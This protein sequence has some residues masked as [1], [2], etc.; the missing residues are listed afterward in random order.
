MDDFQMRAYPLPQLAKTV[1]GRMEQIMAWLHP[2][3]YC[4]CKPGCDVVVG[5]GAPLITKE[6]A[7]KLLE[8]TE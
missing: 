4:D 7:A 5:E 8:G 2:P 3:L 6:L 1:A